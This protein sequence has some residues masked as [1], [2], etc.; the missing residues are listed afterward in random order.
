MNKVM[1]SGA[2]ILLKS[3]VK[4]GVEEVF[5][6]PGGVVLPLYDALYLQNDIKH[7]L[8]RHEQAAV[9]AAEGYARVSGRAGVAIVTSGPGACNTVT[10]LANAYYD[11]TP[12]I[13][14]TGQVNS[15]LIGADAFQEADVVGI[16]R[17]CC[18]HNY[19]VKDVRDLARIIK[20][21]FYIATTGKKG[22]VV[23]DIP[24]DVFNSKYTFD[25]PK[26][27]ELVGY[28]PTYKGHPL[29]IKK[30]LDAILDS[31]R[32]VII[33]GGG[34]IASDAHRELTEL[35]T[36]LNIPVVHTLMG[37][38]TFPDSLETSLGMMGMHGNY[39]ANLTVSNADLIFA[40]GTRFSDRITG[41]LKRF[42]R[43]A[44]VIHIDIDPCSISKNVKASIPIVGDIKNVL[45]TMLQLYSKTHHKPDLQQQNKWFG[46]IMEWKKKV[47]IARK[48]SDKLSAITVLNEI[49]NFTKDD[50]PVVC[51]EVGQ[52][53]MWTAQNFKFN[54]P[55]KLITSGGLGT[56]GFGFPA[57][58]GACVANKN[59]YVLNIAGDGSIQMNIQE[60]MT[61]V[62]Y[63]FKVINCIINN[64][65]L[66]MVRQWQE[67]IYNEH[68]SQTKISSPDFVKL[69]QSYGALGIRVEHEDEI[70]PALK[71]ALSYNGPV[72]IDFI[73]E[74][75]EMVY[76]WVLAG[77]PI[78][79][80][81]LSREEV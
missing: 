77:E 41:C 28:N 58:M 76:P 79:K 60:L 71:E 80:V 34:V 53:Q 37:T 44:Q 43:D 70:V 3:L 17:S 15:K 29:Q 81:L 38:G 27:V 24:V 47:A 26:N 6:Y 16:T 69:A 78:D 75:F 12:L 55:R 39:C 56:M 10:G 30:A 57:A 61:C 1:Y 22:P 4:E 33:S 9:H 5:G 42:A 40:I 50:E 21:A 23:I 46:E 8:V 45:N 25:Y 54:Q 14:I 65:Y 2:E 73:C 48:T 62:D 72:V 19:L 20:E 31:K 74:S 18:K 32:P 64:G 59:K 11:G 63:K 36:R 13:L 52:H 67:K 35:A 66:G 7:Y 68:Y 49:Y 51:T